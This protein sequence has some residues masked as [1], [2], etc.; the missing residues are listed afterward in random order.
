[1]FGSPEGGI[2]I[3]A[4]ATLVGGVT[5]Y[6]YCPSNDDFRGTAKSVGVMGGDVIGLNVEKNWG[7][8][9]QYQSPGE[10]MGGGFI[11]VGPAVPGVALYGSLS[12]AFE[13][14]RVDQAG[15]QWF[16]YVP[17]L[18]DVMSDLGEVIWNDIFHLH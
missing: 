2:A 17:P 16:P 10:V 11:G 14:L 8:V 4:T 1:V 13:G 15:Y 3:G 6:R 7:G 18:I 5:L 9:H 12:Y